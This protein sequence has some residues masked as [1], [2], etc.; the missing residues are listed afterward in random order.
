MFVDDSEFLQDYE[1]LY[2]SLLDYESLYT[3]L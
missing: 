3:F 2:A 1:L